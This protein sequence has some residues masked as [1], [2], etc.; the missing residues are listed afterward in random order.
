MLLPGWTASLIAPSGRSVT[1]LSAR[2]RSSLD[3]QK[4]IECLAA[5]GVGE[6]PLDPRPGHQ[7]QVRM[8]GQGRAEHG[9]LGV[10]LGAGQA[11]EPVHAV[12]PDAR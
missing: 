7:G 6:Q 10:G 5:G 12:A 1:L 3:S 11:R 2:G 9:P 8:R 4:P